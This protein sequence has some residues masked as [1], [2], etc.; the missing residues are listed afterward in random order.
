MSST[1][2]NPGAFRPA[3]VRGPRA[4]TA[5]LVE[6][7][8]QR[9]YRRAGMSAIVDV[10]NLFEGTAGRVLPKRYRCSCCGH[11][12]HSFLHVLSGDRVAWNSGCSGC[13]SRS[14]HRG[15]AVLLPRLLDEYA[16]GRVLHFAPEPVLRRCFARPEIVYETADLHLDDVTHRGVDL[17]HLP[18]AG[19]AYDLVVCNHVLEH[20]PDDAAAV[21]EIA[22][23]LSPKGAAVITV[24]GDFSRSTT[25]CF[26]GE[27][28]NGHYRDYG[29]D[30]VQQLETRFERVRCVDLHRFDRETAG[31]SHGIRPRDLAFICDHARISTS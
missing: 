17:Q 18:F 27:L 30:F 13:D 2:D 23:V 8:R 22:R 26:T 9:R 21:G 31:F 25:I 29:L 16:P 5:R 15:L 3:F 14:R 7:L 1:S 4:I 28:P 20:V 11:E 19:G 12:T 6:L 24:P 10:A